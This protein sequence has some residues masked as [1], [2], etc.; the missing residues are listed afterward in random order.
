LN[1]RL[2]PYS[3]SDIGWCRSHFTESFGASRILVRL[4]SLYTRREKPQ[5]TCGWRIDDRGRSVLEYFEHVHKPVS[6]D[7]EWDGNG[8]AIGICALAFRD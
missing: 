3:F 8:L 7:V 1:D 5:I 2:R 6:V 4:A